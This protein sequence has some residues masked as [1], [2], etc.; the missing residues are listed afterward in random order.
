MAVSE[1]ATWA[2]RLAGGNIGLLFVLLKILKMNWL[3]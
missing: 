1:R 2:G 3:S